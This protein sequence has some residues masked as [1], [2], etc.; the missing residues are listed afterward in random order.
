MVK[1]SVI[2]PVYNVELY[3]R[4]CLDSLVNQTLKDIEII[5]V[6]DGTKDNSAD[7]MQEYAQKYSNIRIFEKP[8][9]GLSDARNFG[10]KYATGEYIGFVDSDDYVETNMYGLMY[11]SAVENDSDMVECNFFHDYPDSQD[12]EIG[13][14]YN[15]IQ[16]M[17]MLGRSVVWNKIYRREWLQKNDITFTKGTNNEDVE[18]YGKLIV[19]L[20]KIS[21]VDEPLVHYVQRDSSL[22]HEASLRMLQIL[23]VLQ[24]I[25]Q[26]YKDNNYYSVYEKELEFLCARIILCSSFL[27]LTRISNRKDRRYALDKSWKMLVE[28]FP[29]WKKNPYLKT[30]KCKKVV[31]MKM[32]NKP[33]YNLLGEVFHIMKK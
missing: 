7:I 24:R 2:V 23:G 11:N 17:I 32:M 19:H 20:N 30:I 13:E 28:E 12:I 25:I 5:L 9:G 31:Y 21:Y 29:Q 8:N 4:K 10:M 27:R 16:H 18:F 22:N 1:V 14:K 15:D 33:M 6:N 3:L 26:Y